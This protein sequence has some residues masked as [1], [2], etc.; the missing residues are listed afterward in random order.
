MIAECWVVCPYCK[1]NNKI[2][3]DDVRQHYNQMKVVTCDFEEG[4][5]DGNFAISIDVSVVVVAH[6][7]EAMGARIVRDGDV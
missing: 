5:C 4:G 2:T 7:I 1:F 3:L 6:T